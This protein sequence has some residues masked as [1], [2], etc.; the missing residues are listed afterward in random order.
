MK[1]ELTDQEINIV[2]RSLSAMPYGEVAGL[3]AS[4]QTQIN[5]QNKPPEVE[6]ADST[7]PD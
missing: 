2:G 4:L 6:N 3:I 7:K 5:E 1:L